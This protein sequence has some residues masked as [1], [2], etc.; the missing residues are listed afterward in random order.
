M[1]IY[2]ELSIERLWISYEQFPEFMDL[3]T[4]S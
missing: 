4:L 3:T 2:T 1:G